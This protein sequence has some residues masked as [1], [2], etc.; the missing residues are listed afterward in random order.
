MSKPKPSWIV[1]VLAL[2]L[3]AGSAFSQ[4]IEVCNELPPP[5][6]G[7]GQPPPQPPP[8][9]CPTI[10]WKPIHV[11]VIASNGPACGNPVRPIPTGD[12]VCASASAE[13]VDCCI[14]PEPWN[15]SPYRLNDTAYIYEIGM[16]PLDH[17]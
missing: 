9:Y 1:A 17:V 4:V 3:T 6:E 8:G 10:P 14:P 13:D 5:P 15:L 16:G 7:C 12:T 2:A 11:C